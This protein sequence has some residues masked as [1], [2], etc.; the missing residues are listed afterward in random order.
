MPISDCPFVASTP[1][2]VNG[3]R[4]MRITWPTGSV[5]PKSSR[6][7]VVPM[8]QTLPAPETSAASNPLPAAMGHSRAC[9]YSGVVP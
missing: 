5:P 6:A 1:I 8:M 7:T 2:T 3:T 4:L 9:R